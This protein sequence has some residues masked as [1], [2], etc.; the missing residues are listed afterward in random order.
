[1]KKTLGRYATPRAV[2]VIALVLLA[3]VVYQEKL[4]C[5]TAFVCY[6]VETTERYYSDATYTTVVGKCVENEC[7]GTYVCSG[8]QT[9]FVQ[10]NT[11]GMLC[12]RCD[13]MCGG[14]WPGQ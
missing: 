14:C 5:S 13:I 12:N 10:T 2:L 4:A 1:M 3:L 11:R 9:E 7:K 6:G 8:I